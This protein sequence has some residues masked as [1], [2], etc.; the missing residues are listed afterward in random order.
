MVLRPNCAD[1][2][3][4]IPKTIACR[5]FL[6]LKSASVSH[7]EHVDMYYA[8]LTEANKASVQSMF[9]G[10]TSLRYLVA[11]IAFGMVRFFLICMQSTH[12]NTH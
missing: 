4:S 1:S 2:A 7:P 11:T 5:V 8:S 9:S 10:G 3:D 12:N 6:F